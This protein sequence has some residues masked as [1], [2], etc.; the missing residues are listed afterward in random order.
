MN[1]NF[2]L[3]AFVSN[4]DA[5]NALVFGK[6][7]QTWLIYTLILLGLTLIGYLSVWGI[8]LIRDMNSDKSIKQ[9]WD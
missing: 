1:Y 4:A 7:I 9:P 5:E 3:F 2:Y 8:G 6:P